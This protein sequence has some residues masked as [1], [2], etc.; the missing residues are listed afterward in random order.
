VTGR[1]DDEFRRELLLAALHAHVPTGPRERWSLT[2]TLALVRWLPAPLDEHADATH[3]TGSAVVVDSRRRVALHRHKRLGRWL[4]PGG[5]VDPGETPADTAVRETREETGL[6]ADHPDGVPTLVH[7]DVHPGPRGHL[8]LDLRYVLV[9]DDTELQPEDGESP[10]VA[11]FTADDACAIGDASLAD[12]VRGGV[13]HL[14][15]R[16]GDPPPH[17]PA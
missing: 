1:P 14:T 5:H 7:V 17:R 10:A 8:H 16:R 15:R 11:W 13:T 12:A 9:T 3:V 6:L 4:Q 2:R